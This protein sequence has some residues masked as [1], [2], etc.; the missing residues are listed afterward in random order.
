LQFDWFKPLYYD[1]TLY[2]LT[3]DWKAYSQSG[4]GDYYAFCNIVSMILPFPFYGLAFYVLL[5][6]NSRNLVHTTRIRQRSRQDFIL[7][8][9]IVRRQYII[10]SRL[11]IPCVINTVIFV[12][13]EIFVVLCTLYSGKWIT[14]LMIVSFA[15]NS[16]VNPI[17]YST[18]SGA[19]RIRLMRMFHTLFDSNIFSKNCAYR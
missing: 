6:R 13:G 10:E 16:F 18:F 3:T 2:G 8:S 17:I 14:W 4:T 7:T 12:F 9:A 5:R 15:S 11:L 19:I 1:P